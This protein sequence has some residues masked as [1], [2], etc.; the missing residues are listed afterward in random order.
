L[1]VQL[2]RIQKKDVDTLKKVH[3]LLFKRDGSNQTVRGNIRKFCGFVFAV[4]AEA[5]GGLGAGVV[6]A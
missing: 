3:R 5:Q 6:M 2:K 4:C 1:F